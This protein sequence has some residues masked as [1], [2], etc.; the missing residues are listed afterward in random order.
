MLRPVAGDAEIR[1]IEV[2][3]KFIPYF[4][5]RRPDV[6]PGATPALGDRIAEK[7]D[8]HIVFPSDSVDV[9]MLV[10]P[11]TA[12]DPTGRGGA[13]FPAVYGTNGGRHLER[14]RHLDFESLQK[15]IARVGAHVDS[16]PDRSFQSG[17]A[18]FGPVGAGRAQTSD[19]PL[20][21]LDEVGA[22]MTVVVPVSHIRPQG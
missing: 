13:I 1:G 2:V 21:H 16:P 8:I 12:L 18:E 19:G 15:R 6:A 9:L 11:G 3:K 22:V 10:E 14:L 4:F 17:T 20:P 5:D 7:N